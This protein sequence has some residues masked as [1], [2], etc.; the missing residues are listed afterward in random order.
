MVGQLRLSLGR[1][2]A[3]AQGLPHLA[4]GDL[5]G[6]NALPATMSAIQIVRP[7]QSTTDTQPQLKPALLIV[8]LRRSKGPVGTYPRAVRVAGYNSEMVGSVRS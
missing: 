7:S 6:E 3:S 1:G 2:R 8:I 4:G 5:N